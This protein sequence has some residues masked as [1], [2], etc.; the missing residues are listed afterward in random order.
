MSR[1]G[2][3][4]ISLP[5]GVNVALKE[6]QVEIVGPKGKLVIN[7]PEVLEVELKDN[8]ILV[9]LKKTQEKAMHGLYRSLINNAVL[10]V[11]VG[12]SKILQL[13]GVGYKA[14]TDGKKLTLM[15]GFSHPVDFMAPEGVTLAVKGNDIVISGCD[16]QL[17]GE[18]AARIRR[19]RP[20]EVYKGKGIKYK[21]EI[22]HLKPGKAAKAVGTAGG[23]A[24]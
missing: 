19:I 24:K 7:L 14:Q 21:G 2:V 13:V 16:K 5:A 11:A 20:P 15:V 9:K 1:I 10:G 18:T 17:V 4:P 8:Q 6:K 23:A 3:Q 12:W 22:I